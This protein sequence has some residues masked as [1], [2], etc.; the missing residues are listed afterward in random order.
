[1]KSIVLPERYARDMRYALTMP[2]PYDLSL[3][4]TPEMTTT[5]ERQKSIGAVLVMCSGA[6]CVLYAGM[7]S[8][9][10]LHY[11][12]RFFCVRTCVPTDANAVAAVGLFMLLLLYVTLSLSRCWV[13]HCEQDG[14]TG[15]TEA[16][17]VLCACV[18]LCS[19]VVSTKSFTHFVRAW[20]AQ[21]EGYCCCCCCTSKISELCACVVG[22]IS[23]SSGAQ[24]LR[25]Q[26]GPTV[27]TEQTMLARVL[28]FDDIKMARRTR[29]HAIACSYAPER[30]RLDRRKSF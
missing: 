4:T 27:R 19:R 29:M 18:C 10:S 17:K 22:V 12:W 7:E 3:L 25:W 13:V 1:M 8:F 21:R 28:A 23:S 11:T 16:D 26:M 15:T 9:V 14:R 5:P 2:P 24:T 20:S 6:Q 30:A